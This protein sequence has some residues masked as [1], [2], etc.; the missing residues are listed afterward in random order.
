MRLLLYFVSILCLFSSCGYQKTSYNVVA[1]DIKTLLFIQMPENVL[2]FENLSPLVY[3]SLWDYYKG[4][5]Y[6]LSN[7]RKDAFLLKLKINK[8]E[9]ITKH[10]SPD[11]LA[12]AT[13]M[14]LE[15]LCSLFDE[16]GKLIM[17]KLFLFP[18][19]VCKSQNPIE[20]TG[21]LDFEY[22]KLM[23]YR[24]APKVEQ[25]FRSYLMK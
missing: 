21:F 19:M 23:K 11:I 17:Q 10:V 3:K 16:N 4:L 14:K 20:N 13:K 7:N 22:T 5:G 25:Y 9:P 18:F 6:K 15:L 12:Y 1:R 2:V 8:L 24:V